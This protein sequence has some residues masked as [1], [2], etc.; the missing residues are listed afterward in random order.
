MKRVAIVGLSQ[1]T[2]HLIP[3][4]RGDWE[5]WGLAW[6]SS[7]YDLHRTFELHDMPD[8]VKDQPNLDKYLA[9]IAQC[10]RPY[11]VEKYIPEATAYPYDEVIADVGDYFCSSIGL[12]LAL[13]IHEKYDEIALYGIDMRADEEYAYQRANCEYLIGL[14]RGRGIK[15]I[16]PEQSPLCKFESPPN[17]EY[18]G[19]YGKTK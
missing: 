17:R 14:A 5:V 1:A 18:A 6:D 2:R 8:M 12:M 19:R 9:N 11:M 4:Y 15:V 7:R 16:V 10:N 3:W 13:A